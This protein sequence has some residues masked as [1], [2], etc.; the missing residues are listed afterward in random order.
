[1]IRNI[2]VLGAGTMGA[3]IAGHAANAGLAVRLLDV[4]RDQ[5]VAGLRALEKSSPAALF[6]PENIRQIQAG[7]FDKD[8]P[9]IS[10]ADWVVEAIV[11]NAEIKKQLLARVD[12]ARRPGALITTNTSGLSVTALAADRSEDF[13]R[14]WFGTHFFNPP[15]YM[16]LLE[17]IPTA[18]TDAAVL[19]NFEEFAEI[20]LGKGVIRAK[21][22]PNFIANRIGM[23]AALKTIHLM[24]RAGFTI[25][26][27]DRLTGPLIGH[28]K[29]ATFRTIDMVGLDIFVH[30][31]ENIYQSAPGDPERET[32]RVPEFVRLMLDRNMLGAK[33]KRGFYKKDGDQILVLDLTSM[34]YRP[35]RKSVGSPLDMVGSIESPTERLKALFKAGGRE[36]AFASELLT[37]ISQ[38]ASARIPEISDDPDAVDRAMRW[39]F[40]WE[41]GP[42][43][44]SKALKGEPVQPPS[45]LKK[46]RV[47][48]ENTGASLRDIG[49]GAA[50]LE[51]HSK[52]NTIGGD[53][54]DLLFAS[55]EEVDRNFEG[56]VIANEGQTF[57]AGANLMLLLM[58][59]VEANWD[60]ID[61]MVRTFQRATQAIRYSAKPVVTAPFALALGGGC[62]IAM[63]GARVQAAA[64]T[65]IGLVEVGAGLIPAGGGTTEM[66]R[67]AADGG[68]PRVR[69]AFENIGLAKVSTS[70]ENARRLYYL[71]PEDGITM[72]PGRLIEDAKAV[73]LEL[74]AT[75]YRPPVSKELPVFGE[76]LGAELKLGIYL[77]K[78]AG[79]ITEYEAH[80]ASKLA[81][82]ICGGEVTRQSTAPE[83][84]FLD[85][86]REAFKSLC[87]ERN[88]LARMEHL[89]KKGKVLRN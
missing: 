69:E 32:F 63:A 82:V 87:G 36:G 18:Y 24:L 50:C 68:A 31:A 35:Q 89:L 83:Q 78:K 17:V 29:T 67:R 19:T 45:L 27:I 65:Y 8:L 26:E 71:R 44:L 43:E 42:F 73:V 80:I 11:E 30:V 48:R 52:M 21:D 23:F 33:T 53:I 72:N 28:P 7:T 39:G 15:R 79:Y 6:V 88:T 13:R 25:E 40:A 4:T 60:E 5:A 58:E 20:T 16:R 34:E 59:A 38:Y 10:E 47:I 51:F 70:A 37:S 55:L 41:M 3:Q 75:G 57:S 84:Y 86:E 85:L 66:L 54:I 12:Q 77:M 22:T 81:Y 1:M 9:L 56:L 2:A 49:D 62:E 64:E 46:H 74:A 61:H 76:P 14:H